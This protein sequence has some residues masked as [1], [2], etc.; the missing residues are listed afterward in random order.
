MKEKNKNLLRKIAGWA[1]ILMGL[2]GLVFPILPGWL[3]I[4]FGLELIGINIVFFDKIKAY[5]KKKIEGERK[6]GE[7]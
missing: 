5:V 4:F 7:R 1:L 6:K 3:L 2:A